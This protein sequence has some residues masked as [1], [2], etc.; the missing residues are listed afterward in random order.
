MAPS[1][2]R[3]EDGER[4]IDRKRKR[5]SEGQKEG[6][7]DR[8]RLVDTGQGQDVGQS[9]VQALSQQEGAR[10]AGRQCF[11]KQTGPPL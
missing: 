9:Q 5:K 6:S 11:E 4:V 2:N 7:R 1:Y 3:E 8:E 10:V